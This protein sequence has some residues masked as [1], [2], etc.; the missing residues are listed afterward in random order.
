MK[1]I[2]YLKNFGKFSVK[3]GLERV[4]LLLEYLDHP[5]KEL[6]VIHIAGTNGKG[7]TSAILTSIYK[8]AGYKVGTYTSPG[9]VEFNERIRINDQNIS[10]P[11]LAKLVRIIKPVVEK[12]SK[13]L[14]H[15]TFFEIL[16]AA[17]LLYFSKKEVELVVLE[18]GLGGR[19]DATNIVHSLI[20][21]ITN[22]SLDH[23][24]YLGNTLEKITW[25]KAGIIEEEQTVITA[26]SKK[27]V[28]NK[29]EEVARERDAKLI[30][31][32][33]EF[34][35]ELK[36][37]ENGRQ[38][39]DL[40][41]DDK[42]EYLDLELSLLGEYQI[43]NA[44]TALG[45]VEELQ[46]DYPVNKDK[47]R[48]ALEK[49]KWPGRLEVV[50]EKPTV[51]LDGAH[52]K[53]GAQK[54]AQELDKFSYNNLTMVLS[55]LGDKDI[56]GMVEALAPKA[57]QIILTRNKNERAVGTEKLKEKVNKYNLKITIDNNL[58]SAVDRAFVLSKEEDL[59][60]IGGSLYTVSE[61]RNRFF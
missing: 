33:Q 51:I 11:E 42:D 37:L 61:I 31:I 4:R 40:K 1:E 2:D 10:D 58:N 30:N 38:I 20:S 16:T 25:E 53:E 9:V 29:L 45:V 52:N 47:I 50:A 55:I 49:V 48:S 21:V 12:V 56:D 19:L 57:D 27:K 6:N 41:C 13:K 14:E 26:A 3:P 32:Q 15:P 8:E 46:A 23:T 28:I 22:V 36:G 60:V 59:I 34:S 39:F 44:V 43:V 24:E 5:E 17:A 54:L 7:S 18:T 35:W